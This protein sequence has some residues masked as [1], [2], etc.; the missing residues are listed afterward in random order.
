MTSEKKECGC[1]GHHNHEHGKGCGCGGHHNH[2]H[3]E[4]C[5]CGGHHN[6][7]HGEGCGCGGHHHHH[8]H[9]QQHEAISINDITV[10]SVQVTFLKELEYR[11]FLPIAQFIVQSSKEG[12]FTVVAL[13]PVFIRNLGDTMDEIKQARDFLLN[14]EKMGLITLD[15]DFPLKGYE[16]DEYKHCNMFQFFCETVEE[17][18][19]KAGFLG[20]TPSLE[21]GSMALT[22]LGKQVCEKE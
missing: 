5:G 18:T 10:T 2:E 19:N 14:L 9:H 21:C 15:Y 22:E 8:H 1:G 12:D 3:G 4:G 6:H 13:A 16:Y 11:G 17:G 20:D 7:E